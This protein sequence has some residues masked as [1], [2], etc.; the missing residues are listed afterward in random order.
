M[1]F[2][3][4]L[5]SLGSFFY[6]RFELLIGIAVIRKGQTSSSHPPLCTSTTQVCFMRTGTPI[7]LTMYS[8]G[9]T[10]AILMY[11]SQLMSLLGITVDETSLTSALY[12]CDYKLCTLW[13]SYI[14]T[15]LFKNV[16]FL[17]SVMDLIQNIQQ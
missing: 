16:T 8:T 10:L 9:V 2:S 4:L 17:F 11:K 1:V 13:A 14:C 7:C 15:H 3:T 6:L 12:T 5:C